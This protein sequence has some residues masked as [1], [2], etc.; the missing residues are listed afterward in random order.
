MQSL[1]SAVNFLKGRNRWEKSAIISFLYFPELFSFWI[2][3]RWTGTYFDQQNVLDTTGARSVAAFRSGKNSVFVVAQNLGSHKVHSRVYVRKERRTELVQLLP[4]S[5][6]LKAQPFTYK[7]GEDFSDFVF[8]LNEATSS[9]I[10]W[11]NGKELSL[12]KSVDDLLGN[13]IVH[14]DHVRS[15]TFLFFSNKVSFRVSLSDHYR[16][17]LTNPINI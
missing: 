2:I 9:S 15:E 5:N 11:W 14:V 7:A 17:F 8:L 3:F 6:A 10:Y 1:E 4:T 13:R 16:Y 12:W